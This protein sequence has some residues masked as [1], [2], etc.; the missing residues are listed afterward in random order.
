MLE[1][2]MLDA[3]QNL[4]FERAASV[5]DQIQS[6]RNSPALMEGGAKLRMS[7]VES[8]GKKGKGQKKPGTAGSKSGRAARKSKRSTRRE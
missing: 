7:E 5:R 1:Q 8:S 6:I 4:E 2:E 3:A